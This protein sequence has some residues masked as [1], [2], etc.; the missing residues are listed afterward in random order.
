MSKKHFPGNFCIPPYLF[1]VRALL[2][3]KGSIMMLE[4]HIPSIDLYLSQD[5]YEKKR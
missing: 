5:D 2:T 4:P 1:S 3:S